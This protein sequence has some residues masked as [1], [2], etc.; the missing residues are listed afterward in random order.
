MV[1]HS[2]GGMSVTDAIHKFPKKIKFAVYIAAT[3]LRTG[4]MSQQDVKDVSKQLSSFLKLIENV[5]N[6]IFYYLCDIF[7]FF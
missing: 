7:F 6:L 5:F 1:G 2:A 3:M 4:F